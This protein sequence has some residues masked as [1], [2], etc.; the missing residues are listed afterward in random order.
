MNQSH[1]IGKK[2]SGFERYNEIG[3]ITGI[4][5]A[6]DDENEYRAGTDTGYVLEVDCPYGTQKMADNLLAKLQGKTYKGFHATGVQL[7]PM[8]ELGDGVTI[9]GI[10][11]MLA[12]RVVNF[13]PGHMSEISAPGENEQ[14]HEYQYQSPTQ[15]EFNRKIAQAYSEIKKTSDAIE[16]KI[17]DISGDVSSLKL[18]IDGVTIAGPDGETR[19]KGSSIETDSLVLTGRIKFGD[20]TEDTQDQI[21]DAYS[22]ATDA[23][24]ELQKVLIVSGGQTYIDGSLIYTNSIYADALHLGGDLEI[25][26]SLASGT[27]GGYLGYTTS[28]N[29]GTA[30]M[31]MAKGQSEVVVT[32]NGAKLLYNLD[33]LGVSSHLNQIYVSSG[34]IGMDIDGSSVSFSGAS[35]TPSSSTTTL[36]ISS[37]KWGQIYSTN[38]VISTSDRNEKQD[39]NYDLSAYVPLFMS[40]RPC[41]FRFIDG[42]SGRLHP[43]FIAQDVEEEIYANG[44]TS[45]DLAA[46]IKSPRKDGGYDYGFRYEEIVPLNTYMIQKAFERLDALEERINGQ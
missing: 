21:N 35:L 28:A 8:A 32:S 13:G 19:I 24:T 26:D 37:Q 14:E 43:G 39:I 40:L 1:Y 11:S 29:D 23:Q 17:T 42:T 46:F 27:V 38:S 36:G 41:V 18:T 7:D 2:V 20:L 30:G 4:S 9:N 15:K 44:L 22:A 33:P 34:Y 12:Y 16:L 31:H 25:Y 3:P 6:V 10:Y 5:L 45:M